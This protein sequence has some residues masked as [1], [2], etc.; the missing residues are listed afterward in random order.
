[1]SAKAE[2]TLSTLAAFLVLFSAMLDPKVSV[3]VA[4]AF[5]AGFALYKF[6]V[7]RG[8]NSA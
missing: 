8:S 4:V 6:L 5:L 2:A 3:I 7:D 1:M